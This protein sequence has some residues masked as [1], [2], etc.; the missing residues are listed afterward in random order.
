MLGITQ[1]YGTAYLI[2]KEMTS[3]PPIKLREAR[4]IVVSHVRHMVI[5]L[6]RP[7]LVAIDGRSG[8]GKSV[9]G[10]MVVT[11]LDARW[12]VAM[13]S[14]LRTSLT[15]NGTLY[16]RMRNRRRLSTGS[17]CERKRWN[18]YCVENR[19]GGMRLTSAVSSPTTHILSN[20]N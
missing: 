15:P 18:H 19:Q 3:D 16:I 13:I 2:S 17:V 6:P 5:N 20:E 7:V 10:S 9:L 4:D 11:E 8:S 1:S 14:T 12:S